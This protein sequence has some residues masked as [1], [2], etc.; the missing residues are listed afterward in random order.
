MG[1]FKAMLIS[2]RR[3]CRPA[4]ASCLVI[5]KITGRIR[6]PNPITSP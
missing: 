1:M 2:A 3:H 6:R 4:S 5:C